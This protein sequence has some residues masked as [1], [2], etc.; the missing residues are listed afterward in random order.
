MKEMSTPIKVTANISTA[1]RIFC[2]STE[3][4]DEPLADVVER[5]RALP[6]HSTLKQPLGLELPA[7]KLRHQVFQG[8]AGLQGDRHHCTPG[9]EQTAF[10]PSKLRE[11]HKD[12]TGCAVVVETNRQVARVLPR[13]AL[14][15]QTEDSELVC[16]GLAFIRQSSALHVLP[17]STKYAVRSPKLTQ[18]G[19]RPIR[20]LV[21]ASSR[22]FHSA[23]QSLSQS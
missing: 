1:C 6:H 18:I 19:H 20:C 9:V 14:I 23:N 4:Q 13:R 5:A 3:L 21:P 17:T 16:D 10:T 8:Y 11:P 15:G 7:P 2:L 22:Q 12:L